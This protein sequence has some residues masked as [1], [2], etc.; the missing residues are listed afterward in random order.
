MKNYISKKEKLTMV[1]PAA[2]ASGQFVKM[3]ADL[4]VVAQGD[5][6]SGAE[7]VGVTEGVFAGTI[8]SGDV[9][10]VG[11]KLYMA[12]TVASELTVTRTANALVGVCVEAGTAKVLIK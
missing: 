4:V 11:Q 5:A 8:K 12:G 10:T 6:E 1:A 7:F 3:S 9:P 2:I